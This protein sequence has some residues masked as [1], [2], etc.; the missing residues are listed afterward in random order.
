MT[1]CGVVG[2]RAGVPGVFFQT[3]SLPPQESDPD[4]PATLGI[5]VLRRNRNM[6]QSKS[7]GPLITVRMKFK[8]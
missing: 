6:T 4:I 7:I 5:W 3:L 1:L 8:M 2:E